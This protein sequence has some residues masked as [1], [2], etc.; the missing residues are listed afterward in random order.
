LG[1]DKSGNIFLFLL[2]QR[3]FLPVSKSKHSAYSKIKFCS[4]F[5]FS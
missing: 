1:K 5:Y 4:I 2:V 3:S